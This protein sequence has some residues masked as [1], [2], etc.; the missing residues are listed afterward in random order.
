MVQSTLIQ[1]VQIR[2]WKVWCR[3]KAVY[4]GPNAVAQISPYCSALFRGARNVTQSRGSENRVGFHKIFSSC[5]L[6]KWNSARAMKVSCFWNHVFEVG[7][8]RSGFYHFNVILYFSKNTTF[9][10]KS[11]RFCEYSQIYHICADCDIFAI[12]RA[13]SV[14]D[15][16]FSLTT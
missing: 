3:F 11:D 8:N 7:K 5:G 15:D 16:I 13:F 14:S 1:R 10:A 12:S 9:L 6:M 2:F 4:H